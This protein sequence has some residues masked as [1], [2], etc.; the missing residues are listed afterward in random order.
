MLESAAPA[1]TR[2]AELAAVGA[3]VSGLADRAWPEVPCERFAARYA[4]LPAGWRQAVDAELDEAIGF[5]AQGVEALLAGA[6]PLSSPAGELAAAIARALARA[7]A[8]VGI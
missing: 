1:V 4:G 6:G 5:A 7:S 3:R 2:F 8:L